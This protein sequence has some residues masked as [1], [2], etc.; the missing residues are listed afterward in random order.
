[1]VEDAAGMSMP[2]DT[3]DLPTLATR[4]EPTPESVERLKGARV[5]AFAGIG[6]PEKFF[7]SLRNLQ[8]D[9]VETRGFPDHHAYSD[10]ELVA[11]RADALT[12]GARLVTTTKDLARLSS[13]AREGLEVLEVEMIFSKPSALDALLAPILTP[14]LVR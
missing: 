8:C 4:L 3:G 6:R 14:G 7:Q 9:M 11:L 12:A 10:G 5:M 13:K 1:M 2:V